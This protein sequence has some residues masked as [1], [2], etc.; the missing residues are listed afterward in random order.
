MPRKIRVKRSRR[1]D[2]DLVPVPVLRQSLESFS[3]GDWEIQVGE[4][5]QVLHY[6]SGRWVQTEVKGIHLDGEERPEF[7]FFIQPPG[8]ITVRA[9]RIKRP[10]VPKTKRARRKRKD[11][12]ED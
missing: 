2:P 7:S 12:I 9:D 5:V 3:I 4:P 6:S 8:W 10:K 1:S 11:V